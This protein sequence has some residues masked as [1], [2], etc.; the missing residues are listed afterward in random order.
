MSGESATVNPTTVKDRKSK[1]LPKISDRYQPK[2]IFNADETRLFYN[3]QPSKTLTYKG[4]SLHGGTK[5]KQKVAVLL[6]CNANGT[7]K[8]PPLVIGKYNKT[9]CFRNIKKHPTKYT[10]NSNSW[11]T[12][13]TF[14]ECLLQLD[15]QIG[16]KNRKILLFIDK[17]AAHPRDTPALKNIKVIFLPP[18]CTSHLQAFKYQ[19]SKQLMWKAVATTDRDLCGDAESPNLRRRRRRSILR[20]K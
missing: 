13:A 11:M 16:A 1:D 20:I 2:D 12:S 14:E 10:V 19:Y 8:L 15:C 7:E 18:N 9:H 5:S 3:L 4:D 6:G 17:C